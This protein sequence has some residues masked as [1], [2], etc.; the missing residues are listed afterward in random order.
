[1]SGALKGPA[2]DLALVSGAPAPAAGIGT[3]GLIA[4]YITSL[5]GAGVLGVLVSPPPS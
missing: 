1:M 2:D 3:R 4:F 5:I